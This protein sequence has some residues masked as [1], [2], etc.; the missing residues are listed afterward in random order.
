MELHF[1]LGFP[2]TGKSTFIDRY[3]NNEK[4]KNFYTFDFNIQFKKY[5]EG[6][7]NDIN[8]LNQHLSMMPVKLK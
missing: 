2:K 5:F 3:C 8:I 4:I 1:L 7:K 6:S